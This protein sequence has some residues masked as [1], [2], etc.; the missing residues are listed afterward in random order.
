MKLRIPFQTY[1]VRIGIAI[2]EEGLRF[3]EAKCVDGG[4]EIR[5]AGLIR[6][7]DGCMENGRI[8]DMERAKL[9]LA[10]AKKELRLSK[11]KAILSIPTSTVVIRKTR[12]P[13]LSPEE[14]RSLL[15]IELGTTI[16]LPFSR[17]YFDFHKIGEVE[18]EQDPNERDGF[19]L[20]DALPEDE[21][22]VI[23]A[24]GDVIDPYIELLKVLDLEVTAV[25]IEPLALYRLLLASG[26]GHPTDFMF[27]QLGPH[28]VNVSI[29]QS[30]IPEFLRSIPI[31]M[32]HYQP[33]GEPALQGESSGALDAF[34]QDLIREVDR[35]INF[36]QFSMKNDGT[37]IKT[38]YI[39]GEVPN[40]EEMIAMLQP[41]MSS[42]QIHPLPTHHI[43]HQPTLQKSVQAI[44]AAAGLTLRG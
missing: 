22:L 26:E 21:Y 18:P 17:P 39:T 27:L 10:L 33:A 4:V 34:V 37:R 6:L 43:R 40:L 7:E 11:K 32:A 31:Q 24:P 23:A 2:E 25:D 8:I 19:G 15:E 28:A 9:Q 36:Y 20:D 1:P 13:R 14:I 41:R 44:T 30:D 35:V 42:L 38:I 16:H 5:Q 3:V 12:Q 29:F